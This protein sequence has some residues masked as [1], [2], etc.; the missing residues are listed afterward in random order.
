M[1]VEEGL[2]GGGEVVGVVVCGVGV[3]VGV[4]IVAVVGH[5]GAGGLWLAGCRGSGGGGG[6]GERKRWRVKRAPLC[7]RCHRQR[8]SVAW[9]VLGGFETQ[10]PR[11]CSAT[12]LPSPLVHL[13]RGPRSIPAA[14]RTTANPH[15][16]IS[17]HPSHNKPPTTTASTAAETPHLRLSRHHTAPAVRAPAE[18][19]PSLLTIAKSVHHVALFQPPTRTAS[20]SARVQL[21][22]CI[23]TGGAGTV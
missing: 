19:I 16:V 8:G 3:R 7:G 15:D 18:P 21:W 11:A 1:G 12:V 23:R 6:G 14:I 5:A 20:A 10:P 22:R 13:P 2:V 4:F 17:L 9:D